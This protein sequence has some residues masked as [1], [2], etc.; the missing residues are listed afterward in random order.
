MWKDLSKNDPVKEKKTP[1]FSPTLNPQVE[2]IEKEL[3]KLLCLCCPNVNIGVYI[4]SVIV[5]SLFS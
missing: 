4:I 3:P 1:I 5:A 2:C